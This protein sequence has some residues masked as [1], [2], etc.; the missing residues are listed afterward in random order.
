M[1]IVN[2]IGTKMPTEK[3]YKKIIAASKKE[4]RRL[5]RNEWG[6]RRQK[7]LYILMKRYKKEFKDIMEN[8]K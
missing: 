4:K 5:Y 6:R 1:L 2:Q 3:I 7:A 8:L